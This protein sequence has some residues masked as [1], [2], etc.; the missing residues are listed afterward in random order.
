MIDDNK[1]TQLCSYWLPAV[2]NTSLIEN[3]PLFEKRP[4]SARM[5]SSQLQPKRKGQRSIVNVRV[6]VKIKQ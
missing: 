1:L 5:L 2:N 4:M 3:N 6:N